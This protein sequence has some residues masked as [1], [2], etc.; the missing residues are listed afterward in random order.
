MTI[1]RTEKITDFMLDIQS[2]SIE[3]Y[4]IALQIRK[5]YVDTLPTIIDDIKYGGLVFLRDGNLV[6]GVFFYKEHM[7]VEFSYGTSLS[8]PYMVLEGKGKF[9]RHIK[10][11]I[12]DD[13][14]TKNISHYVK[15]AL[16]Q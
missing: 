1:F 16:S 10:I 2:I 7:S 3:R 8:D 9:R 15:E 6:G 4:D 14:I 5:M 12:A 13:I 11:T